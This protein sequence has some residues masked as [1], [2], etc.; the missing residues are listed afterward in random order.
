[1]IRPHR[2]AP[3]KAEQIQ[4][5]DDPARGYAERAEAGVAR[6]IV[7]AI[8]DLAGSIDAATVAA[9]LAANNF[10][11]LWNHLAL[12]RLG[13]ALRPALNR[14]AVVH[15][16]TAI[17]ETASIGGLA[18]ARPS[19]LRTPDVIQ[20][21][22]D[23]LDQQTVAAQRAAR[24]AVVQ[25]IEQATERTAQQTIAR[26]LTERQTPAAIARDLR[27]TL[28]MTEPEA[29]AIQSYRR[30]LE[31]PGKSALN[32]ALRD[33]RYDAA[34]R[35]AADRGEVLDD[36]R[37]DRMVDRYADKYRAYRAERIART[38]TLRAANQG[39]QDAWRQYAAR[40]GRSG[41]DIRKF[42][43]TAGDE[44]VCPV[45]RAIPQWNPDGVPLDG[46]YDS[47]NGSVFM[48]PEHPFC[49]CTEQYEPVA[50]REAP[51]GAVPG[52]RII[53]G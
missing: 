16:Q 35:R 53:F 7:A 10:S 37:I 23:P 29:N 30:A 22:Y 2:R 11:G 50:R 1:M 26:G 33:R 52:L 25:R 28:S 24:E 5:P 14:L 44:L 3:L 45:C 32:R 36:G 40:T 4:S 51:A 39:R 21:T 12:E 15:D 38:E 47:P 31:Q 42:W 6:A 34:L 41:A 13:H 48:P 46:S 27:A 19:F 43:L 8:A 9:L 20:L 18:K 49:R 17:A